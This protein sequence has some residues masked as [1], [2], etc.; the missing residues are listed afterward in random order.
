MKE[1][2]LTR[3]DVEEISKRVFAETLKEIFPQLVQN[4][5]VPVIKVIVED[6]IDRA[7]ETKIKP[8]IDESREDVLGVM[9]EFMGEVDNRFNLLEYDLKLIKQDMVSLNKKMDLV[10]AFNN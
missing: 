4:V 6:A 9:R 1:Q 5:L 2:A 8:L 3:Q 10:S 7:I